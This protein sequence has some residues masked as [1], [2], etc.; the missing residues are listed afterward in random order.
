MRSCV[1]EA[2]EHPASDNNAAVATLFSQTYPGHRWVNVR[3]LVLERLVFAGKFFSSFLQRHLNWPLAVN[4]GDNW[5]ITKYDTQHF[6]DT[7]YL[8]EY[9]PE[10]WFI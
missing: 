10:A 4:K 5:E 1:N 6:C 8:R 2:S 9:C 3:F 7:F